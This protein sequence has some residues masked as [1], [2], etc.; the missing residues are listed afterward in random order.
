EPRFVGDMPHGWISSDYIRAA[1][2]SF[3][4]E[5]EA[6]HAL[7]L[8]EG[9]PLDWLRGEGIGLQGLRTP[10]GPLSYSMAAAGGTLSLNVEA[11]PR[12][13]PGGVVFTWPW[14]TAPGAATLNG[15]PVAWRNRQVHIDSL[16]A[17]LKINGAPF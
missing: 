1:L 6:D 9:V 4:Y 7:L 12:T 13:P 17:V 11:M 16:P 2:D 8:A 5:R 10:Y 3:A 15:R 14:D